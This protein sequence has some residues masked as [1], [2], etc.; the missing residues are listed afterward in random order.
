M[1]KSAEGT[2][3]ILIVKLSAVGDVVH[4]LPVLTALRSAFP[5][6]RLG[7]AVH[8]GP[9]NLLEGHPALD[10]LVVV[11]RRGFLKEIIRGG[12]FRR[13]LQGGGKTWDW[14]LDL[15]GLTKSG[16]LAWMSGA[17]RR[18]GMRGGRDSRELNWMFMTDRVAPQS[19][20]IV[21]RNLEVLKALGIDNPGP[22]VAQLHLTAADEQ[23]IAA[24]SRQ[25]GVQGERFLFVDPFAGWITKLWPQERWVE[26]IVRAERELGLRSLI[27]FGP[28]ER[29]EAEHLAGIAAE[30][31]ATPVAAPETTLRQYTALLRQHAA[32]F[33]G[34][35]TGPMH[36]AA[37]A[38][39]PVVALYGPSDSTRNAPAFKGARFTIVEDTTQ[40][41][42]RTFRRK[43]PHHPHPAGCMA[44]ISVEEVWEALRAT[45]G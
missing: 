18:V 22:P 6:A 38:G 31:G 36:I 20:Q 4:A 42:A 9:G 28:G 1:S 27:F 43:C 17:P 23:A 44:G 3:N 34:G 15:Q 5:H 8:P 14:A 29:T 40:P 35:D 32:L 39:V 10:E 13:N 33:A 30:K 26:I 16:L 21:E 7:W 41:C 37:A 19:G 25:A 11:P 24:W 12:E 2:A 45:R